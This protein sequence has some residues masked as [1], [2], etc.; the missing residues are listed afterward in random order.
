MNLKSLF[1]AGLSVA[2]IGLGPIQSHGAV[3]PYSWIR[4]GEGGSIFADSSGANHAF[5]A[6]FSSGNGGDPGAVLL[7]TAVGGPLGN[8][9]QISTLS[10]RFGYYNRANGGMWIQG[11]NNTP[12]TAAQWSLPKVNWVAE[13]WAMPVDGRQ[14]GEIFN[15]G[16]GQFG[17][18]P[19]GVAFRVRL[20]SE[21]GEWKVR[22]DSVGPNPENRFQIGDEATMPRTRFT[23]MAAVNDNGT[24]TFYV[25]GVQTGAPAT[26]NLTG[27]GGSPYIGSGQ[28]TGNPFWGF[29]DEVRYSTFAPGAFVVSDLL[30][31]PPGASIIAQPQSITV[32]NGAPALFNVRTP[33]DDRT[34]FAWKVGPDIIPGATTDEYSVPAV[35]PA[36]S[37]KIYTVTLI[38]V[39]ATDKVSDPATLTVKALETDNNAFY[40]AAVNAEASLLAYFPMD[41]DTGPTITNTKDNTHNGTIAGVGDFDGRI[42]RAYGVK[43]LRL[44]GTGAAAF[45]PNPAYEF[46]DGTGTIEALIYLAPGAPGVAP[47]NIFAVADGD[48][49][50]KYQFQV[51]AD[52]STLNYRS[53]TATAGVT[54]VVSPSLLGRQ[55]HVALVIDGANVT[56]YVDGNSLGTKPNL[57]LGV[58]AGATPRIGAAGEDAGAL[59]GG[60]NG[61]IDE[62]AIYGDALSESAIAIHNSRFIFGTAVTLPTI[63]SAPSGTINILAGGE[64]VLR[65]VASGTAPLSYAW[66][67]DNQPI[68]NNPSANTASLTISRSTAASSGLYKVTVTNPQGSVSSDGVTV[69][70]APAPAGDLYA[71]KVLANGPSAY[72]RFNETEA[73]TLIDSAG[74]LN[75]TYNPSVIL[76]TP[77]PRGTTGTALRVPNVGSGTTTVPYTPTLNPSGPYTIEFWAQPELNGQTQGAVV[78][79]QNRNTGRAGYAVYQGFNVNGWEAHLGIAET[80]I[81]LQGNT[82]PTAGR[83]D[84]VVATWDGVGNSVLYVNGAA[85][86]SSTQAPTRPNLVQPFEIGSRFGGQVRWRGTVDEVAFYNKALTAADVADHFSVSYYAASI[87]TQPVG[88]PSA[89]DLDT[90]TLTAVADGFPNTY[91][92]FKDNVALAPVNNFDGTAHYSSGVDSQTLVITKAS[93][94]DNGSYQFKVTNRT[95]NAETTPVSVTVAA[96]DVTAPVVLSTSS[97]DG[98]TIGLQFNEFV[99]AGGTDPVADPGTARTIGNYAVTSPAGVTV[100]GAAIGRGSKSVVLTVSGLPAKAGG[101][102]TVKVSNVRD[103]TRRVGNGLP[104]GGVAVSGAVHGLIVSDV[105]VGPT[106]VGQV[107]SNATGTFDVEAGGAD[108]WGATDSFNFVYKE[109]TG[110]FDVA[111]R[112][113]TLTGSGNRNGIMLRESLDPSARFVY[114]TWNPGNSVGYHVR[115]VDATEPKWHNEGNNW[116]A[117]GPLPVWLRLKNEAGIVSAF[118]SLDEFAWTARGT[119]DVTDYASKFLGLATAANA[120]TFTAEGV[121]IPTRPWT[122]YSS[123]GTFVPR[124]KFNQPALNAGGSMTLT[125]TGSGRLQES[126]TLLPGSWTDVAGNPASG[127]TYTPGSG[128]SY[129]YFRIVQ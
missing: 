6:A 100:T 112:V 25:N 2:A 93:P 16:T 22:L 116:A 24:V 89:Q 96:S 45:A 81:F 118:T 83:W 57:G 40:R 123:Y 54:W 67:K 106:R 95:G 27:A 19:G 72:Y 55:A 32:W 31:L 1:T 84:H 73:T 63:T 17:A 8:T 92:W 109:S 66:K 42:S 104:A 87:T 48:A 52:G 14:S 68:L 34:T 90:I 61:N 49:D 64:P 114:I 70:F 41:G 23:H 15:T 126:S 115:E 75:G 50:S 74:G 78:A 26:Q 4:F 111:V 88:A 56:A 119:A 35:R 33:V 62:L 53:D 30:L 47:Q 97:V 105:N 51:N 59:I 80:V 91:Q 110:D 46:A 13:G 3:T 107:N 58:S 20:D 71:A 127:Y 39:G 38:Q 102:F 103:Y 117:L 9:T 77:G 86:S 99:D 18:T 37:G 129:K 79:T 85:Q 7:S 60:F 108:V 101:A 12:P 11:P 113:E 5:N 69:N 98:S 36:D 44:K 121:S 21:S 124:T 122:R 82:P 94:A 120:D 29:I 125:W 128:T 76:G 10:A 43:S 65:A 28:D